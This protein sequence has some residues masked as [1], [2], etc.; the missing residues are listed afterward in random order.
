MFCI[1]TE[2]TYE[3]I[4]LFRMEFSFYNILRGQCTLAFGIGVLIEISKI[5]FKVCS[6]YVIPVNPKTRIHASLFVCNGFLHK[7][8]QELYL[9]W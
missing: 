5:S 4:K 8:L 1:I 2:E 9:P 7:T 3:N 6:K